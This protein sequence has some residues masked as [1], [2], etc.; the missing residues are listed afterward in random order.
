MPLEHAPAR[1]TLILRRE[2]R[3]RA[4]GISRTTEH[5]LLR[6]ASSGW[7]RPVQIT[8]G[9]SGYVSEEVD[10]FVASRI[11]ARDAGRGEPRERGAG[12]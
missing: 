8:E 3:K 2:A 4:G 9:L 11:A 10:R 1:Q 12:P 7:P 5:R 6:D